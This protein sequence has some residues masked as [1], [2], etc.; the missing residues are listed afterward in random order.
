[1]EAHANPRRTGQD[2]HTGGKEQHAPAKK[3]QCH[4]CD[5]MEE[6]EGSR[7]YRVNANRVFHVLATSQHN[8]SGRKTAPTVVFRG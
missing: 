7:R 2:Q 1:M 6:N 3:E 5:C 8:N 4:D